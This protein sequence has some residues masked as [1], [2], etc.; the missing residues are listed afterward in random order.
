MVPVLGKPMLESALDSLTGVGV[1]E[2]VL[3]TG[4]LEDVIHGHIGDSY[5][6][7]K[8]TYVSNREYSSTNNIYSLWLARHLMD[9][10]MLLLE[11]DIVFDHELVSRLT[12]IAAPDVAVVDRY[13]KFMDG[14]V[15]FAT[16]TGV[17]RSM[18]L[19]R[20]QHEGFDYH[21]A[22]KTVNI[23]KFSSATLLGTLVP[24]LCA[25][26]ESG[27][28]GHYYEAV[29]AELIRDGSLDLGVLPVGDLRWAEIDT[30]QDM[31]FA[32]EIFDR[33]P[34]RRVVGS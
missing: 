27:R 19:K 28:T 3:V 16:K 34:G 12:G 29:L 18:V 4:H 5:C 8:I 7:M 10:D 25:A 9:R 11:C 32:L 26:I 13:E 6:G 17:A 23:Y 21:S 1:E 14:T 31:E 15:V 20:D 33:V 30:P 24:A 2:V 22:L